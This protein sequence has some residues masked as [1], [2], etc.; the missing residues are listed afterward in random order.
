M[1]KRH[2]EQMRP[3]RNVCCRPPPAGR[4]LR[5]AGA[6][7]PVGAGSTLKEGGWEG[8]LPVGPALLGLRRRHGAP[9][10]AAHAELPACAGPRADSGIDSHEASNAG[11]RKGSHADAGGRLT[12]G[13]SPRRLYCCDAGISCG[14]KVWLG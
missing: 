6:R 5:Y 10:A 13:S 9:V 7:A 8:L 1:I 3:T 2:A 4:A 14:A 12:R 11:S